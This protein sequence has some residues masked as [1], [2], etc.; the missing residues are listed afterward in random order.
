MAVLAAWLKFHSNCAVLFQSMCAVVVGRFSHRR[1]ARLSAWIAPRHAQ[2]GGGAVSCALE[3]RNMCLPSDLPTHRGACARW[4]VVLALGV[5][6]GRVARERESL[7]EGRACVAK[8]CADYA[9]PGVPHS[10]W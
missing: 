4:R 6:F 8:A 10:L 1:L 2:C 9:S 7:P 5:A 3:S